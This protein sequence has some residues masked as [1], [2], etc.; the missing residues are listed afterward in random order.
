M[1]VNNIIAAPVNVVGMNAA[2]SHLTLTIGFWTAV[3]SLTI[4]GE[5]LASI[6]AD[7]LNMKDNRKSGIDKAELYVELISTTNVSLN[8]L[9][10]SEEC[11][12]CK[13][14]TLGTD[15]QTGNSFKVNATVP[16]RFQV[17]DTS[18]TKNTGS[19][20]SLNNVQFW[21][22]GVYRLKLVHEKGLDWATLECSLGIVVEPDNPYIPILVAFIVLFT[23]PVT[24]TVIYRSRAVRRCLV[25][26]WV[27]W[28]QSQ[29]SA[30]EEI[31]PAE[32]AE[33]SDISTEVE[34]ARQSPPPPPQRR[35]VRS[36]DA[37]RGL[38][39]ILMIFVNYGGGG[40][41]F[42][43]HARWNG[44][45]VADIVF[46][47]FMWI[48]GVSTA[49]STRSKLRNSIPRGT[50]C[51]GVCKR[52][53]ILFCLGLIINSLGGHN[54]LRN[55]RIP[56]VLQRFAVC[57]LVVGTMEA[58]LMKRTEEDTAEIESEPGTVGKNLRDILNAK[59]QWLIVTSLVVA[60]E[61]ITFEVGYG[62]DC[63]RGYM[64]PG[65]LHD[66]GLYKNCTGGA[67]GAVDRAVF[68]PNH[69]Y[70]RP[71]AYVIYSTVVP[72]DPEGLLGCL[73]SILSVFLG[74]QA[75]KTL[76]AFGDWNARVRR[77][78]AW[79]VV[80]GAAAG[81]FCG[82]SKD[83][84]LIPINKNLWSLSF[85][86]ATSAMAY[87]LLTLMY[88]VIDVSNIWSGS[89]FYYAGMNSILL[90]MG[91]EIC[92]D[93]FPFSWK[94]FTQTHAELLAMNIWGTALWVIAAYI[95][96]KKRMFLAL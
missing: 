22:N 82:F 78:L 27:R 24:M 68:G 51:W 63:P 41:W 57:Y 19:E 29:D 59:Y 25:W 86:L 1:S 58:L 40:Y 6:R 42:F 67:A 73:T 96:F 45:T 61:V 47:W 76:L 7:Q 18:G 66:G 55:L 26:L 56:G 33:G 20:C 14:W 30:N 69:M 85:A 32:D 46:P 53:T 34:Q 54:D 84:G 2:N 49:I 36:L 31:I 23:V 72:F 50:I 8:L 10:Q 75:G 90:Y 48:M 93:Y 83:D 88:L 12:G 39:I 79:S 35:R 4:F 28:W 65:G 64:G 92:H 89:P 15:I 74:V 16:Q 17:V 52:S 11:V 60:H 37:F 44:L 38:A 81:A 5:S 70:S 95:L 80:L 87:L 3:V 62:E 94:L 21:E 9:F 91:H 43:A 71:T 13:F 77:W